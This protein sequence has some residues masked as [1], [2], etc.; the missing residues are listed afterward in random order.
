MSTARS[1]KPLIVG[2][3]AKPVGISPSVALINPKYAHN[4]G[5]AMR[6]CSAFG[7]E[8]LWF[9]GD[10][11]SMDS[12]KGARL[13]REERMKGYGSVNLINYDYF[14]DAMP[15]GVTPVAIEVRQDS[16]QL[17]EFEHPANP[18]YVFGPE[19]GSIPST[20]LRHCHRFVII[21]TAHCLNLG[22]AV[23]MVLY[24][25]MMKRRWEG[26]DPILPA[27]QI[28]NEDRGFQDPVD[29]MGVDGTI[30]P[31]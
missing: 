2:K 17:P 10:R 30:Q 14:F 4:V 24:D 15:K 21:P 28:L 27:D 16:E 9:T 3:N 26:L 18:L 25:R 1:T 8:Q 11:V 13:P 6:S 12:T 31:R 29:L 19:D 5:A 20:V 23:S 22:H 7:I